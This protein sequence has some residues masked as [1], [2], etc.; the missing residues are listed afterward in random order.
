M[1]CVRLLCFTGLLLALASRTPADTPS[2]AP[3]QIMR[4]RHIAVQV[5]LNGHGPFRMVLDTG[6]PV[7]FISRKVAQKIGLMTAEAASRPALMGMGGQGTLK[8]VE[9]GCAVT[10]DLGV[11]I[12]DHPVID[13]VSEV[14][15][16]VAGIVGFSFFARF[17][18]TIDYAA[19]RVTFAP[20]AYAPEDAV[21]TIMAKLFSAGGKPPVI[22]PAGLWGMDVEQAKE[23]VRVTQVYEGGAAHAA[24]IKPGDRIATVEGRWTDT[25][26]DCFT[27]A[28]YVKP[29]Q[30]AAVKVLRGG[31]TLELS[32]QPRAGI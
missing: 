23:G 4:T 3:L 5:K 32:V 15:G 24:G 29:G 28:S 6:S 30:T 18:T 16:P 2:S 9:I 19:S 14:E 25:L 22:A 21:R 26:N 10:K 8:T 13:L 7:T 31:S 1:L 11:L 12:L 20:S 17:K 27:A